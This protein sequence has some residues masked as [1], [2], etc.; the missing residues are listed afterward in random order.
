MTI[1]T[2]QDFQVFRLCGNPAIPHMRLSIWLIRLAGS[3]GYLTG[4][5]REAIPYFSVILIYI[6]INKETIISKFDIFQLIKLNRL[7]DH[8]IILTLK[9]KKP[10]HNQHGGTRLGH[11]KKTSVSSPA[12]GRNWGQ[13]DSCNFFETF[14][15]VGRKI[16]KNLYN[17]KTKKLKVHN[18]PF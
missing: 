15:W 17:K 3:W 5:W 6:Y 4:S 14:F 11:P 7:Q 2:L 12:D 1:F 8:K 13:S 9:N 10:L 16:L 18:C